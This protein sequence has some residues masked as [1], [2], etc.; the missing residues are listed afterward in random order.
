MKMDIS[1]SELR[2]FACARPSFTVSA[3]FCWA[4]LLLLAFWAYA[5]GMAGGFLLDDDFNLESLGDSSGGVHD[6]ESLRVYLSSGFSGPTGRPLS[7]LSFLLD[8]RNWPADPEPFKRTNLII[9]L[10]TATILWQM[11]RSL[12]K[13][14]SLAARQKEIIALLAAGNLK[15]FKEKY[16]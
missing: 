16:T 13:Q 11:L 15:T 14:F 12:L 7:L 9:H 6:W 5:P 8:A 1:N 4:A 3:A 2:M 10:A